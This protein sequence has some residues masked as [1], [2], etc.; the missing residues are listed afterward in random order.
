MARLWL[1][2]YGNANRKHV[3][4]EPSVSIVII[5]TSHA[6]HKR[7]YHHD[8]VTRVTKYVSDDIA[9]SGENSTVIKQLQS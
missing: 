5:L 7:S 1:T 8:H 9:N 3:K 6:T 2:V 4:F